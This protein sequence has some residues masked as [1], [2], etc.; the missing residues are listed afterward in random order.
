MSDSI[1]SEYM[2]IHY[3]NR[4]Y[5]L[6]QGNNCDWVSMGNINMYFII[7]NNRIIDVQVD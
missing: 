4:L 1:I 7:R 2:A 5:R 3:P 6:T